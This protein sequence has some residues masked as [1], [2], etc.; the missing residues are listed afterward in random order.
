MSHDLLLIALNEVQLSMIALISS[1]NSMK[2][3][4]NL[5]KKIEEFL[6]ILGNIDDTA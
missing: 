4:K 3:T 5:V 2:E 6:I 1:K